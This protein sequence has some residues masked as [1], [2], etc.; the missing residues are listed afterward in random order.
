M[1]R[2]PSPDQALKHQQIERS[3]EETEAI[4]F[5]S[6]I[7]ADGRSQ[8]ALFPVTLDDLVPHYHDCRSS[9]HSWML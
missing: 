3:F 6:F 8:G 9:M 2:R 1:E 5:M 4:L 7:R